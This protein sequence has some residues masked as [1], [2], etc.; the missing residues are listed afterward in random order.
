[1]IW[2]GPVQ[3]HPCCAHLAIPLPPRQAKLAKNSCQLCARTSPLAEDAPENLDVIM[4]ALRGWPS[5]MHLHMPY[6]SHSMSVRLQ[7]MQRQTVAS[8]Q[9]KRAHCW[10]QFFP[11]K[12]FFEWKELHPTVP[13]PF[14]KDIM[15]SSP[16]SSVPSFKVTHAHIKNVP[17]FRY[18]ALLHV[19]TKHE[20]VPLDPEDQM[21]DKTL[22]EYTRWVAW[23]QLICRP[24]T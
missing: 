18:N 22:T 2:I 21:Y 1:L 16:L 6:M 20:I 12:E 5:T 17:N 9:Y 8:W 23:Q 19:L 7:P 3:G 14:L 24:Y 4:Q 10:V 11:L 15:Q 13:D